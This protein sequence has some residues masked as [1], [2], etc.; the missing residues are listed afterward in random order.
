[1]YLSA[2]MLIEVKSKLA[3]NKTTC[4]MNKRKDDIRSPLL[5]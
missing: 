1:M 3:I 5:T 4:G 2:A